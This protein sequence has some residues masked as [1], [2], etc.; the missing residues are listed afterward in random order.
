MSRQDQMDPDSTGHLGDARNGRFD[1]SAGDHH[2]VGKFIEYFGFKEVHGRIWAHLFL[3]S[4]QLDAG[5]LIERLKISKA[6]VS[7]SISDLMEYDVVQV[8]GKGERG[9]VL[10]KANPEITTVISNVL[11]QRERRMLSHVAAAVKSLKSMPS[12]SKSVSLA[13]EKIDE[14]DQMV[15]TAEACLD[16]MLQLTEVSF[17]KWEDFDKEFNR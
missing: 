17:A 16:G 15:R 7:M 11:R 2:Q 3:S 4:H 5:S 6:L 9:I 12:E 14:L 1:I 10:Y 13:P 8:A